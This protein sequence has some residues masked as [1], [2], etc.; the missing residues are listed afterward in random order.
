M[1]YPRQHMLKD[2]KTGKQGASDVIIMIGRTDDPMAA[3]KR[4]ISTP[5]NKRSRNGVS[6]LRGEMDIDIA[7][8][9][10]LEPL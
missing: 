8:G 6:Y 1:C 7:R 10:Y 4:F 2:S 5:K 9:R 3:N